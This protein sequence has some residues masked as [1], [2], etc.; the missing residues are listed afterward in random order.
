MK[1]KELKSLTD[2]EL[3]AKGHDLR[4]ELFNLRLR[5]TTGQLENPSRLHDLRRDIARVE[6]LLTQLKHKAA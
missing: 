6:T 2:A 5:Q 3:Q 1:I 4:Q